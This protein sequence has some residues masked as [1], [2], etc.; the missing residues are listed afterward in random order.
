LNRLKILLVIGVVSLIAGGFL[1]FSSKN[2]S[3]DNLEI[4]MNATNAEEAAK[5]ISKNNRSEIGQNTLGMGL[6]GFG[7]AL[8]LVSGIGL[9][10]KK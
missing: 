9:L 6:L 3:R 5:L 4:A 2:R 10:K 1:T 7:G 8:T